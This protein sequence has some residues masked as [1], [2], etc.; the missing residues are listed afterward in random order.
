MG[1]SG[2]TE[3]GGASEQKDGAEPTKAGGTG[4]KSHPRSARR[5]S[6]SRCGTDTGRRGTGVLQLVSM[7]GRFGGGPQKAAQRVSRLPRA[8]GVRS[9]GAGPPR[10]PPAKVPHVGGRSI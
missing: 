6:A 10:A 2:G 8:W 4:G 7:A 9:S 3:R 1:Y 5:A